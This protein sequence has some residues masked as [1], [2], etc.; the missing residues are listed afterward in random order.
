MKN[1]KSHL[2]SFFIFTLFFFAANAS[3]AQKV[4][5]G[6]DLTTGEVRNVLKKVSD[7]LTLSFFSDA[8]QLSEAAKNTQQVY[9]LDPNFFPNLGEQIILMS[10]LKTK[11]MCLVANETALRLV[12]DDDSGIGMADNF[13]I[14]AESTKDL[15]KKLV[16]EMLRAKQMKL[17]SNACIIPPP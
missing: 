14:L 9:S 11:T 12:I 5:N 8:S 13:V 4:G 3:F 2:S 6:G 15:R 16:A 10:S 1:L 7:V 17:I